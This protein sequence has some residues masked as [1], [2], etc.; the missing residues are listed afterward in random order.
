MRYAK[1]IRTAFLIFSLPIIALAISLTASTR[2]VA[3]QA[4]Q[5]EIIE[6][7]NGG[8]PYF[9][10]ICGGGRVLIGVQGSAGVLIDSVQ[11]VCGKMEGG[12]LV[13]TAQPEGPVFGGSRPIDKTGGCAGSITKAQIARNKFDPYVGAIVFPCPGARP[14]QSTEIRGSGELAENRSV[15][16]PSGTIAVGIAG[17]HG[18][19]IDAFGLLCGP[20]PVPATEINNLV[21]QN[22]S[23][24]SFNFPD[25]F[26]RHRNSLGFVEPIPNELGK[27]D[28]TFTIVSGL[29]GR[30]VSFESLN[31]RH[32]FLR[33]QNSRLKLAAF[34][35]DKLFGEDATFCIVSGLADSAG[36]SFESINYPKHYIRHKNFELWLDPYDGTEL[37]RRDATFRATQPGGRVDVR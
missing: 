1:R 36:T 12:R 4:E 24:Q 37:F 26:I 7:G 25:R 14:G 20:K 33:H 23:F 34:S 10:Y 5:T 21:G 6:W 11:A 8:N 3:Q 35:N 27:N 32:H 9:R 18:K 2:A 15:S 28:A 30:C 17:R 31:Y 22:V 19:Y 29:A 13:G 16:C